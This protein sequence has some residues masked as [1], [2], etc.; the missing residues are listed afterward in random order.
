M[1]R[2][3]RLAL[4][5]AL[6]V[7]VSIWIAWTAGSVSDW[8]IAGYPAVH[9]LAHGDVGG[10]L[11]HETL[12]GPFAI[13]VEAP[14]SALAGGTEL[15]EY[16][17]ASLPC[18]FALGCLGVYLASLARHRGA[19][20]L[21]QALIGIL[22]LV[23]PLTFEALGNG[24]PEE[25]L[26]A[27]LA[28]GAIATASQGHRGR[29]AVLLGL[30]ISS[31]QWAL[32]AVLPALMALPGQRFRVGLGA[33]A[34]VALLFFPRL[35][36]SPES[37]T[38]SQNSAAHVPSVV[39]PLSV[40][41]PLSTEMTERYQV[42]SM[43]LVA[44][45]HKP[46][47]LVRRFAHPLVILLSFALPPLLALRR[48]RLGLAAADA[49]ALFA[50]L[51]LLRCIL[52]PV[53]NL[54]YHLPFL[55]ALIGWDALTV[56]GLP[57]R[58]LAGSGV[59]LFFW[60]WSHHLENVAAFNFAYIGMVAAACLLIGTALFRP[61]WWTRIRSQMEPARRLSYGSSSN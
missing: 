58:A 29:T 31:K 37:F 14:F 47:E 24:H 16:R 50:L 10:S 5:F 48:R 2:S 57:V 44:T 46:A 45:R 54:Y 52:D 20:P 43:D 27:S 3:L 7:G 33:I 13:L 61:H 36:A 11:S 19:S 18:L 60:N 26:T 15:S 40:W 56:R 32:I 39:T 17:W 41:Y 53:D 8:A 30:A 35:V 42:G 59:A 28:V 9:P 51:A 22:C 34:I 49:M 23:N 25:L 6:V 4:P 38:S 55:V 21:T 12:M 1:D